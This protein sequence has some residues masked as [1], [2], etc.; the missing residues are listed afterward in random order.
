MDPIYLFSMNF[1]KVIKP[2][3]AAR[4]GWRKIFA[5][6][7]KCSPKFTTGDIQMSQIDAEYTFQPAHA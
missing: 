5:K 3:L 1:L 7:P 2:L 4:E 6:T